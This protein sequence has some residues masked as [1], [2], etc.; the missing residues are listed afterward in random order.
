MS[1]D[2][3]DDRALLERWQAGDREA[4][5]AFVER[6]FASVFSFVRRRVAEPAT[7]KDIA[8]QTFLA[9][10]EPSARI[11]P[12][13]TMRV[14]LLGIARHMVL[15]HFRDA[16]PDAGKAPAMASVPT[17]SVAL[18]EARERALLQRCLQALP[19]LLRS[20]LELY[21]WD[22]LSVAEIAALLD[23]PLGTIKWRLHRGRAVLREQIEAAEVTPQ[24]R[25]TT[26][27][28][29]QAREV[30]DDFELAAVD[31]ATDGD[32]TG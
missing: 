21:Y 17:P 20:P 10:L 2:T 3:T 11:N 5:N 29:L 32:D 19:E 31:G 23:A 30:G 1:A 4:G 26:L 22:E 12:Q 14:Y 15:R 28:T 7:A 8:Q 25:A 24:L 6:H 18:V 16:T 13:R 9:C 27:R